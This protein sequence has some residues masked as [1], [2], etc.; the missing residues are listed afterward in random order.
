MKIFGGDMV[1]R[2][3]ILIEISQELADEMSKLANDS[4]KLLNPF[5]EEIVRRGIFFYKKS[6]T[7]ATNV[8]FDCHKEDC[9]SNDGFEKSRGNIWDDSQ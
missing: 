7:G 2:K 1:R 4:R 9:L 6:C 3:T 5:Y 8:F